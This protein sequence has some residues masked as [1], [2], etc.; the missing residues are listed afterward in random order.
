MRQRIVLMQRNVNFHIIVAGDF[1]YVENKED[2][3]FPITNDKYVIKC[4]KPN[5]IFLSDAFKI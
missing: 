1:N 4:F 3:L 5:D 2:R